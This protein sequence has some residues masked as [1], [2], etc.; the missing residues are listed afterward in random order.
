[1]KEEQYSTYDIL[2]NTGYLI[3]RAGNKDEA[4]SISRRCH[5]VA[6][7]NSRDI[8]FSTVRLAISIRDAT[9]QQWVVE[10]KLV[11]LS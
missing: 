10:V 5:V 8:L 1:M 2:L 4:A 7:R 11:P 6:A 3:A 9:D